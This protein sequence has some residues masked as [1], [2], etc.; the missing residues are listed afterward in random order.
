MIA[1]ALQHTF[2]GAVAGGGERL[3]SQSRTI[4]GLGP[5]AQKFVEIGLGESHIA[6]AEVESALNFAAFN[7]GARI[8]MGDIVD[9]FL[10]RKV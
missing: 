4:G 8:G 5:L 6:F 7:H 2:V 10:V 1:G 3:Q 9:N